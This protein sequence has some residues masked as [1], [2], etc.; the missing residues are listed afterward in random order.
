MV[1]HI[2][3]TCEKTF[4]Q[5]GHLVMHK[6]RKSP[7][8]KDTTIEALVE[9]KVKE[10]LSKTNERPIKVD[11]TT[12]SQIHSTSMDYSRKT[13]EELIAICKEK[14]IKKYSGKK[15][16][17]ILQLV[18]SH[19]TQ[20]KQDTGKFRINMKDQF[21][22]K[23]SIAKSCIQSIIKLCPFVCDYLWVEPSAGNGSFLN[24]I[25][26]SFQKVGI[27]L[28]PKA[29]NIVKQDYLKWVPPSNKDIIVFGNPPFGR[30]SSL[31]K[32]FISKSCQFAKLIA[33]ILPKS[34]T[35]PSMYNVF[36]LKFH[37]VQSVDLEKNSFVL[38]GE[39]YDVPC[40]FQIWQK[41]DTDRVVEEKINPIGFEY[42]KPNKLYH[43]AF[44]R[45]GGL[46]G[47]SY[48]NDGSDFSFQSHYFIQFNSDNVSYTDAI[49]ENI[50]NHI[51]PSN[52][53]GPRSLSKSEANVVIND[54]I[55]SLSSLKHEEEI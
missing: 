55:Q 30:Q 10:A 28:E 9:Q 32:A 25:P 49:I 51:F 18:T 36:D 6:K 34:F 17:V 20:E 41:C 11:P 16:D 33:F 35:K 44:R 26:N 21:Y 53:V 47:K 46:A 38:N 19:V 15:R 31:A 54:I 3:E 29:K 27:D 14:N 12:S 4:T 45:V 24:N 42:V 2:C 39:K 13:R 50:N 37:L 40:V 52:T 8:K 23:N 7:C 22:T 5:K 1:K 43:M 48:K